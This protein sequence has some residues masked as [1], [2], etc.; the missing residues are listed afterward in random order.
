MAT[1]DERKE[2]ARQEAIDWQLA[3]G[4]MNLSYGEL[5]DAMAHFEK[6]ARRYGLVREFRENGII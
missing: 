4:E 3:V 5:S 1:Y 2:I 6:K